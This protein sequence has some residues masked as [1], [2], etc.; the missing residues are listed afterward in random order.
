M[1]STESGDLLILDTL[2]RLGY[3]WWSPNILLDLSEVGAL[4]TWRLQPH[5]SVQGGHG[6][7]CFRPLLAPEY[8]CFDILPSRTFGV[9]DRPQQDGRSRAAARMDPSAS[10]AQGGK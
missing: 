6:Q 5:S 9:G 10:P 8:R 3:K 1:L 4:R 7:P 2:E